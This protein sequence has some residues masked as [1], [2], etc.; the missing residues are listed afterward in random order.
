MRFVSTAFLPSGIQSAIDNV[1]SATQESERIQEITKVTFEKST[2]NRT[3]ARLSVVIS[4]YLPMI[5]IVY[6]EH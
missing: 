3:K 2:E 1:K 4:R 6:N 5:V